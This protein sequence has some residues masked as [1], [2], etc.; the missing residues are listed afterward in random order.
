MTSAAYIFSSE[1]PLKGELTLIQN[2]IQSYPN[3][4]T[5]NVGF[6]FTDDTNKAMINLDINKMNRPSWVIQ[7]PYTI[8]IIP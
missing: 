6:I 1:L 8:S 5:D 3:P 4:Y 7:Q 2:D